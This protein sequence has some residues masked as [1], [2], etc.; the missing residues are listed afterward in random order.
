MSILWSREMGSIKTSSGTLYGMGW[1][2]QPAIIKWAGDVRNMMNIY[3]D[4]GGAFSY[5]KTVFSY[6]HGFVGAWFLLLSYIAIVWA[7]ATALPVVGP[8]RR[9]DV[10]QIGFG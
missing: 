5:I 2:G 8:S 1:T 10:D 3:P 9:E 7:N 4:A 6:D